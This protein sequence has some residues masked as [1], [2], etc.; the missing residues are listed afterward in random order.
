[1]SA[2]VE[3]VDVSSSLAILHEDIIMNNLSHGC[4]RFWRI[5]TVQSSNGN[6]ISCSDSGGVDICSC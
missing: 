5:V 3:K 2:G 1:M 6:G 4:L